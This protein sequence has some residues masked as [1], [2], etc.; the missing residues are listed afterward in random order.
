MNYY[1]L[2][3]FLLLL[4]W[5]CDKDQSTPEP[6]S[7]R[8]ERVTLENYPTTDDDGRAWDLLDQAD[9]RLLLVS[10]QEKLLYR[11]EEVYE[12]A[13]PQEVYTFLARTFVELEKGGD[14]R[15]YLMD[16]DNLSDDEFMGGVQF[17]ADFDKEE[18]RVRVE[19]EGV[20]VVVRYSLVF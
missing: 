7:Y 15:L 16:E 6:K 3:P 2:L 5:S 11:F 4:S 1:Y 9:L 12:N 10:D 20:V 19:F 17:Y 14:Y 8:L 18:D 13:N